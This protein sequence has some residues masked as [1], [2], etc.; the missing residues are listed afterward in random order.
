MVVFREM[1]RHARV[2]VA[3]VLGIVA[4]AYF[5]YHGI[6]GD[7]GIGAWMRINHELRIARDNLANVEADRAALDRRVADMRPDHVDP[8]LLDEQVRR[9]LDLAQPNEIVIIRPAQ[10][11]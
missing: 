4:T 9:T 3:P 1:R 5:I 2:L 6:E 7:R 11:R 10:S 8:D